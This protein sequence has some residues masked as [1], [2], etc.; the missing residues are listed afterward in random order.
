MTFRA[1]SYLAIGVLWVS[2]L[3][4]S[5]SDANR[6]L[7]YEAASFP[8]G[9]E[10]GAVERR[11]WNSD[12][13]CQSIAFDDNEFWVVWSHLASPGEYNDAFLIGESVTS[14]ELYFAI[15]D[16]GNGVYYS[17]GDYGYIT[18]RY[19]D[20]EIDLDEGYR[21]ASFRTGYDEIVVEGP[22]GL[23]I[24]NTDTTVPTELNVSGTNPSFSPS[25]TELVYTRDG[26]AWIYSLTTSEETS[27]GEAVNP[28]FTS[29]SMVLAFQN[30][31]DGPGMYS[32]DPTTAAWT[33]VGD[34]DPLAIDAPWW[35]LAPDGER[36]LVYDDTETFRVQ[37][38][39]GQGTTDWSISSEIDCD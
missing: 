2:T 15:A 34:P 22:S 35:Q 31:A 38:W 12:P 18:T 32:L 26:Q 21:T 13:D 14:E 37:D 27:Y 36:V 30:G 11:V 23:V 25:G 17:F 3:G 20:I 16:D 24:Y 19:G 39:V 9:Y 1:A 6:I 29:D 5:H 10:V 7:I 8:G 33:Y 28:R 4:C